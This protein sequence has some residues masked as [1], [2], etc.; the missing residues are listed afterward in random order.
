MSTSDD[1]NSNIK[2]YKVVCSGWIP[3]G[4][5]FEKTINDFI[6]NGWRPMGGIVVVTHDTHYSPSD[7]LYQAIVR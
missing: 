6:K 3:G 5:S 7:T 2:E 4:Q 1:V